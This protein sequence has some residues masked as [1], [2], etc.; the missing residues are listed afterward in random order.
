MTRPDQ[1]VRPPTRASVAQL[2][3]GG[4]LTEDD[5]AIDGVVDD[6]TRVMAELRHATFLSQRPATAPSS[7][8]ATYRSSRPTTARTSRPERPTTTTFGSSVSQVARVR[9]RKTAVDKD[10]VPTQLVLDTCCVCLTHKKE[11]AV[12]PCFHM[13]LCERCA[14]RVVSCPLCRQPVEKTQK[15]FF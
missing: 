9:Y 12:I 3:L 2:F 8:I 1:Q 15:I 10:I 7:R 14:Q 11:I 6:N 5:V 4:F 13:C